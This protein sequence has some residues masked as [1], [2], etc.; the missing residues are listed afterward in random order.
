MKKDDKEVVKL[1]LLLAGGLV[2]SLVLHLCVVY[3]RFN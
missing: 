2:V 3:L 1:M